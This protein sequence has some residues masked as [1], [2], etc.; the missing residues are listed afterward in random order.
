M[1]LQI[2]CLSM[3]YLQII[4]SK[5]VLFVNKQAKEFVF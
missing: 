4:V 3:F 2:I 1:N 5:N